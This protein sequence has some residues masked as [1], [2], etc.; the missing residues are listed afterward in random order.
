MQQ[1]NR[2]DPCSIDCRRC[3]P[4]ES[5]TAQ[6]RGID[7]CTSGPSL[8]PVIRARH[9]ELRPSFWA[10]TMND[11]DSRTEITWGRP[12]GT[13]WDGGEGAHRPLGKTSLVAVKLPRL[14]IPMTGTSLPTRRARRRLVLALAAD[15]YPEEPVTDPLDRPTVAASSTSLDMA[16]SL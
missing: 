13:A 6:R 4:I 15:G 8:E 9:R 10:R 7:H 3:L 12:I 5:S 2:A 11:G 16:F 1:L 14:L